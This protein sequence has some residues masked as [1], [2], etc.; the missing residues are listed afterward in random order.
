[1]KE[2]FDQGKTSFK[3]MIFEWQLLS[4]MKD[5][6]DKYSDEKTIGCKG[7]EKGKN[8]IKIIF[9]HIHFCLVAI[10]PEFQESNL[11]QP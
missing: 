3:K 7:S 9:V 8:L 1:V 5:L 6:E 2:K 11:R 4:Y 10:S